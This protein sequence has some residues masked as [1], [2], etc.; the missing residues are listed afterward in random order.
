MPTGGVTLA[1]AADFIKAGAAA[2]G[3]GADLVDIGAMRAGQPQKVTES[4]RAYIEAVRKA[5][6][7]ET[8]KGAVS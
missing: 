8:I 2:I 6:G 4:A 7:R 3:V 1:T 5:R